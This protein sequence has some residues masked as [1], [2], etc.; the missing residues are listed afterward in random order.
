MEQRPDSCPARVEP[1]AAS[2]LV[3]SYKLLD[4]PCGSDRFRRC[5]FGV[6]MMEIIACCRHA[7]ARLPTGFFRGGSGGEG[8]LVLNVYIS[9]YRFLINAKV[10]G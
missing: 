9:D 2:R 10:D 4:F 5:T 6:D 7:R 3:V 1:S 8:S